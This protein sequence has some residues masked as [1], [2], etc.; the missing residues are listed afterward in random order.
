MKIQ[1]QNV[2][3][4]P[5]TGGIE[6]YLYNISKKLKEM[7]HKPEILCSQHKKTL[8]KYDAH[9]KIDIIRHP[10]YRIDIFPINILNPIYYVKNLEK[11]LYKNYFDSNIIWSNFFLDAFASCKV[12]RRRI[13]IIYFNHAIASNLI[14]LYNSNPTANGFVRFYLTN[15]Y[16]QYFLIE[17][18]AVKECDKVVALSKMR[19]KEICDLY[20]LDMDKLTVVPP[21]I[22]LKK[23]FPS[24]KDNSLLNELNL[25]DNCK[26][27][28]TVG[29]LSHEKNLE[30]LIDSFNKISY[31]NIYLLIVGDGPRRKYLEG[32]VKRLKLSKKIIFTGI[33]N[34]VERFYRI[35]DLFVLT[36]IYEGFGLVYLE[37]M[38]SGIPCIGLKPDYPKI[39]VAS[40]EIINDGTSGFLV[41]PYSI[42]D[43]IE[44][45][46]KIID[47][48]NLKNKF[49]KNSRKICEEKF[50]WEKTVKTLL[51][52]SESLI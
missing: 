12:F 35:A 33:R 9:E 29:R 18:Q 21:G 28:L 42:D 40:N 14:K 44:K 50:S 17:K 52:E 5:S 7:D 49:G 13:P 48:E 47:D 11:F 20:N 46:C 19:G 26:I 39:I 23:F 1:L 31:D 24:K 16:P 22:D 41:D 25:P 37:A 32:I 2:L 4:Y 38:S 34:D 36:S 8:P 45:I 15:L 30:M 10:D 51:K 43:L 6:S 3:Y 27:I